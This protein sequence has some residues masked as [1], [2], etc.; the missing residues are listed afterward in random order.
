MKARIGRWSDGRLTIEI[1]TEKHSEAQVLHDLIRDTQAWP[2]FLA[3]GAEQA[4]HPEQVTADN[5][6]FY[7]GNETV[8][9]VTPDGVHIEHVWSGDKVLLSHAD[10]VDFV[11]TYLR[12]LELRKQERGGVRGEVE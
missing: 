11:E 2:E 10:F 4:R 12:L 9:Q 5:R 3:Q 1:D 7:T 6:P 8:A